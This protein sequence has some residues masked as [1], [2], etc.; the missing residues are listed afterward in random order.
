MLDYQI[1]VSQDRRSIVR[2]YVC[3]SVGKYVRKYIR[4]YVYM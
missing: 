3:M 1:I 2:M 4:T